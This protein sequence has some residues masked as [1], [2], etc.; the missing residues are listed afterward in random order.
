MA[1]TSPES[2]LDSFLDGQLI[3]SAWKGTSCYPTLPETNQGLYPAWLPLLQILISFPI[4]TFHFLLSSPTPPPPPPPSHHHH[5]GMLDFLI[6]G[7]HFSSE[8]STIS[9]SSNKFLEGLW[10]K[11]RWLTLTLTLPTHPPPP[12]YGRFLNR[13]FTFFL[14][15]GL[16]QKHMALDSSHLN[17]GRGMGASKNW[18]IPSLGP[19]HWFPSLIHH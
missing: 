17:E 7:S 4:R 15:E 16:W 2:D 6:G 11:K 12:R 18:N 5:Q 8:R 14:R 3:S 9:D 19:Y 10:Q 13:W 1:F